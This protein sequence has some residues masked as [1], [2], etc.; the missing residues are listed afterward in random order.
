MSTNSV[1]GYLPASYQTIINQTL[2]IEAE[3]LRTLEDQRS[4]LEKKENVIS[5]FDSKLNALHND[6]ESLTSEVSNPFSAMSGEV[7]D[8]A[9]FTLSATSQAQSGAHS[10][11]VNRLAK[12]DTRVSKDYLGSGGDL[13]TFFDANGAQTFSIEVASPTD[14]DPANREATSVTVNPTGTSNEEI[15]GEIRTA[16]DD[17]MDSAA[18]NDRI[19]TD[20]KGT[21]SVIKE[22]SSDARLSLQ[23]GKTGF[24]NRLQFTDSGAGLLAELGLTS[25]QQ[26]TGTAGGWITDPGTDEE[27]SQLN[28]KFELDGL[29]LYRSSNTVDDALNGITLNLN[30]VKGTSEQFS[31]TADKKSITDKVKSFIEKYNSTLGFIKEKGRVNGES[32][33]RGPMA[34]DFLFTGLR[35]DMREIAASQVASQP[36]GDP[37][38]LKEI[39]IEINDDGTLNLSDETKLVQAIE[40][41]ASSVQSL[42][43]ASDGIGARLVEKIDQFVSSD[44]FIDQRQDSYDFKMESLD[45][46]INQEDQRLQQRQQQLAQ[47]FSA[48]Y[49]HQ[50]QFMQQQQAVGGLLNGLF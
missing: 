29:T 34:S 23:G 14:A 21:I 49:S 44:G 28:A 37:S 36:D 40:N 32:G 3:R 45:D 20:E 38:T 17:A 5:D 26:A 31:I 1:G 35:L 19:S 10:L 43:N 12:T 46:R 27:T 13:R 15:L 50:Q 9:G 41:G 39:G 16:I 8:D 11:T 42:F 48:L 25:N 47:E 33:Y 4:A 18:N 7:A 24:A 6:L 30:E 2:Q 22:T